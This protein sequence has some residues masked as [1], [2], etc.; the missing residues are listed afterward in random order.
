MDQSASVAAGPHM[1]SDC[2]S[3]VNLPYIELK[4]KQ[5]I[6]GERGPECL[7]EYIH[8]TE[9]VIEKGEKV[10]WLFVHHVR[11]LNC[12]DQ[13]FKHILPNCIPSPPP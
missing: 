12:N 9:R 1:S 13:R 8:H 5:A 6:I 11:S 3:W 4:S 7:F 10:A 2:M